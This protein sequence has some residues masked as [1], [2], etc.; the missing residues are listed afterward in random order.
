MILH[1][2]LISRCFSKFENVD[3]FLLNNSCLVFPGSRIRPNNSI[4][5][6]ST[7]VRLQLERIKVKSAQQTSKMLLKYFVIYKLV[8]LIVIK[9]RPFQE[10]NKTN[11]DLSSVWNRAA[12]SNI[13]N[14]H[15]VCRLIQYNSYLEPSPKCD[16]HTN[17][18]N[19]SRMTKSAPV[20][21]ASLRPHNLE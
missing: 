14:V 4:L 18:C 10:L 11:E 13:T 9:G 1:E 16:K 12:S 15:F 2:S 21:T 20:Q 5:L 3:H 17:Y 7:C 6:L 19:N 8:E